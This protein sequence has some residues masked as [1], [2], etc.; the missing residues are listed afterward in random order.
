MLQRIVLSF[1]DR[2]TIIA[3][4]EKASIL[5]VRMPIVTAVLESQV[6]VLDKRKFRSMALPVHIVVVQKKT[7]EKHIKTL[8][9]T[10]NAHLFT[11][12]TKCPH[13]EC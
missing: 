7:E 6:E 9:S 5:S 1:N 11:T 8:C 13:S 2:A 3:V 4:S 10:I 12:F